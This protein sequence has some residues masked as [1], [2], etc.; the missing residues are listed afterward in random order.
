M[1]WMMFHWTYLWPITYL[2]VLLQ[3]PAS[4]PGQIHFPE[5]SFRRKVITVLHWTAHPIAK[6][7]ACLIRS[8]T[9]FN[10]AHQPTTGF[11]V[12]DKTQKNQLFET[13]NSDGVSKQ[14]PAPHKNPSELS[15]WKEEMR[16]L[17]AIW[18]HG[19]LTRY[20]KLRVAHAPGM[21][22]TFSPS[23]TYKNHRCQLLTHVPWCMSGSLI[24]GGPEKRS[25][26]YRRMSK[27]V[28]INKQHYIDEGNRNYNINTW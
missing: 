27:D 20:V 6:R 10:K 7:W 24:H 25:R 12:I 8:L 22:R 11:L 2:L 3:P 28:Y 23:P 1:T 4:L 13:M 18:D 17:L 9:P 21:P 5:V 19:P 26:H 16:D 15:K 14:V